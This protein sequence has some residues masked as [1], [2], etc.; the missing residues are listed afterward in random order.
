MDPYIGT[1]QGKFTFTWKI[2]GTDILI[3]VTLYLV[4]R[5]GI[6]LE[7]KFVAICKVN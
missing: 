5:T 2:Y 6:L 1:F 7:L 3:T 4:F